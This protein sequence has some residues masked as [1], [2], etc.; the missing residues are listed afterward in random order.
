MNVTWSIIT[1]Q[2][3]T[4]TQQLPAERLPGFLSSLWDFHRLQ[5]IAGFLIP[6]QFNC[7]SKA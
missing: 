3:Y 5:L 1:V 4:L 2:M 7:M 6:Q